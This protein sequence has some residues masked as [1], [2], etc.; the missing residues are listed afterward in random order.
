MMIV[1][2]ADATSSALLRDL[3]RVGPQPVGVL[4]DVAVVVLGEQAQAHRPAR[5]RLSLVAP[6]RSVDGV[7]SMTSSTG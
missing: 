6:P 4:D 3:E 2:V 5:V 7:A 1:D